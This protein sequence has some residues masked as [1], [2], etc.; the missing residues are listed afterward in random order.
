MYPL[1]AEENG[2]LERV[3]ETLFPDDGAFTA[4]PV[5]RWASIGIDE[6]SQRYGN[7]VT[8]TVMMPFN[9]NNRYGMSGVADRLLAFFDP[10]MRGGSHLRMEPLMESPIAAGL[11]QIFKLPE[12]AKLDFTRPFKTPIRLASDAGELHCP[13]IFLQEQTPNGPAYYGPFTYRTD[14]QGFLHLSAIDN[15]DFR[16]YRF[17]SIPVA[18]RL[19]LNKGA[20]GGHAH[21]A[22][23]LRRDYI[24]TLIDNTDKNESYDWLPDERMSELFRSI[25]NGSEKLKTFDKTLLNSL[26]SAI[27]DYARSANTASLDDKRR[28][29]LED[30]VDGMEDAVLFNKE[31]L[32]QILTRIDDERLGHIMA[33]DEVYPKVKD[34]LLK[35][36]SVKERLD[37]ERYELEREMEDIRKRRDGLLK[38]EEAAREACQAAHEE[39]AQARANAEKTIADA[40]ASKQGEI[41]QLDAEI[42]ER[43]AAV[44][45]AQTRYERAVHSKLAVEEQIDHILSNLNNEAT[46]T[47]KILENEILR[48]VVRAV[49]DLDLEEKQ[50]AA[51]APVAVPVR[52]DAESMTPTELVDEIASRVTNMGGRSISRN[53][54]V[55]MVTC[56]MQGYI[57]TFA[58]MPG[59]G[60]TSMCRIVAGAL[61]LTN[62]NPD[63]SRFTEIDVENGWTSYK[64]YIG[65]HNP[66]AKTYEKTIPQVFDAMKRLAGERTGEGPVAPYL[67]L[68]D[69]ANLSPIEH[70]WGPFMH[71]CDTF[72]TC[73]GKLALGRDE[74]WRLPGH[75]RF[76]ATVN[77]DH[78]TEALS[79]RFLDRSWV[80]TLGAPD[81][82]TEM[83][84]LDTDAAFGQ[85]IPYSYGKLLEVFG[86][87]ATDMRD[88][89]LETLF[90]SLANVCKRNGM[91][92]SHRSLLMMRRYIASA[93]P[94]MAAN[95]ASGAY[96]ALDFA[97]AQKVLPAIAGPR[98]IVAPL[99][100]ELLQECQS[101]KVTTDLLENMKKYGEDSG[102]YQY[103]I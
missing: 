1:Y 10:D 60:K 52:D 3:D 19:S 48:K 83:G 88:D 97:F 81:P 98:E 39:E 84:A 70:Y 54:V 32:E 95:E 67:F 85:G 22:T 41:K 77:Y 38:E 91:P 21:I 12:S 11:Y 6:I 40:L 102:Y 78:T 36:A 86:G 94:L 82:M 92:I 63:L 9:P 5:N 27:Y 26:K 29:R 13:R 35:S 18:E 72:R 73:G 57:T 4:M 49:N 64:D 8:A 101:L 68:L 50:S 100:D 45:E 65:Y 42:N 24:D 31:V 56:L 66:I 71:A 74:D 99:V 76:M 34:R 90:T 59:T 69:E 87:T 93:A 23:F 46:T 30:A 25:I 89:A 20:A 51:V 33:S 15:L 2:T 61:G 55:N 80:I 37:E 17:T 44:A 62:T 28:Q 47:G 7:V 75:M 79:P 103:F 53:E 58:G 14:Q 16:V 96:A 43:R